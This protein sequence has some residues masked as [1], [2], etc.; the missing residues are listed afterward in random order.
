MSILRRCSKLISLSVLA[1]IAGAP[2]SYGQVEAAPATAS[3]KAPSLALSFELSSNKIYMQ[4]KV[5]G[6]GPFPFVLDTGA[7]FTVVDW[8]LAQ[9]LGIKVFTTGEVGGAGHGTVKLGTATGVRL[10]VDG[11]RY[12]PRRMEIIPLKATLSPVEG[13]DVMGLLGGD[14]LERFVSEFDYEASVVRLHPAQFQYE[15]AA[16]P[17]P[18]TIEGH[19]L[20]RATVTIAGREPISGRFII[21]TGARLA[22]SLNTHVVNEHKLLGDDIP[23]VTTIVGWGLGGPLEHGL[24][25]AKTLSIGDVTFNAPTVALSQDTRGVL[26]SRHITG[27]I[28]NEVLK[29]CRVFIDYG[30]DQLILEPVEAAMKTPFPADCSGLFITA[31]GEAGG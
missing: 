18:V 7:P 21:D 22:L 3:S 24:T 2:A 26:A 8:E 1:V 23:H 6:Q 17:Q 14:V 29:R 13:R 31:G 5:N 25:R 10:T 4:T 28:G 11:L 30:R 19:V 9:S 12:Q 27:I 16:K 20:A 15:G